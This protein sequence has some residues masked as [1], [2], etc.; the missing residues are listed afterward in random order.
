MALWA[1]Y[2]QWTLD[3]RMEGEQRRRIQERLA[4][5][6][7]PARAC[8]VLTHS[9]EADI[10]GR[11]RTSAAYQ[12]CSLAATEARR[13]HEALRGLSFYSLEDSLRLATSV[14]SLVQAGQKL[15]TIDA[16]LNRATGGTVEDLLLLDFLGPE[17]SQE[18]FGDLLYD[19][20]QPYQKLLAHRLSNRQGPDG[21]WFERVIA[22][23]QEVLA[24]LVSGL[25]ELKRAREKAV[26]MV[27]RQS[28]RG[29]DDEVE[30]IDAEAAE[31]EVLDIAKTISALTEGVGEVHLGTTRL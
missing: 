5:W 17:R 28:E 19:N 12:I 16:S 22:K 15:D 4:H 2:Q 1:R 31:K 10:L 14:E 26:W 30:L 20:W 18:A 11:F 3:G 13:V 6:L 8:A 21:E 24:A 7:T 23:R 29:V 9:S 25:R 27:A